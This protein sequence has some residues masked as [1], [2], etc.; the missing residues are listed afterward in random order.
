MCVENAGYGP[1]ADNF[2]EPGMLAA[3]DARSPY[4]EELEMVSY[5]EVRWGPFRTRVEWEGCYREVTR[6]VVLGREKVYCASME[7][8]LEKRC[9]TWV[10]SA[11]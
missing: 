6:S 7:N 9:W 11:L 4:A 1:A 3:E 2:V 10:N 8:E 5:V